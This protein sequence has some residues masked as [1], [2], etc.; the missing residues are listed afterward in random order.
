MCSVAAVAADLRAIFQL[1]LVSNGRMPLTNAP[2][3]N[4]LKSIR[5]VNRCNAANVYDTDPNYQHIVCY[6][7][8]NRVCCNR[9]ARKTAVH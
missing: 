6:A 5:G 1:T 7:Q 3:Q 8:V 9:I 4:G 2:D